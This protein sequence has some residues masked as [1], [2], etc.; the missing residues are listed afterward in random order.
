MDISIG[1]FSFEVTNIIEQ[2]VNSSFIAIDLELSGIPVRKR[3]IDGQFLEKSR[4]KR[5]LQKIYEDARAAAK[6]FQI[7][8]VGLTIVNETE[9]G[10]KPKWSICQVLVLSYTSL[11][12]SKLYYLHS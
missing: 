8:Q 6:K 4:G 3:T 9:N 1:L 5:P 10:M 12:P 11:P 2:I 7:L